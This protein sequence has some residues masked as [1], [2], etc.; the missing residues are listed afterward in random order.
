M[1]SPQTGPLRDMHSEG[2]VT[3]KDPMSSIKLETSQRKSD[4]PGSF[5]MRGSYIPS[6][7]LP[8]GSVQDE[9]LAA[10]RLYQAM[11]CKA[12]FTH[13]LGEKIICR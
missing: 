10:R 6:R 1:I 2:K 3:C 11:P 8:A 4:P 5:N 9:A 12:A 7:L 13:H